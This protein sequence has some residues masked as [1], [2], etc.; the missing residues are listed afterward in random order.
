MLFILRFSK[1]IGDPQFIKLKSCSID[2]TGEGVALNDSL[3]ALSQ[4][5]GG[6]DRNLRV[7]LKCQTSVGNKITPN[8]LFSRREYPKKVT[9]IPREERLFSSLQHI[10]N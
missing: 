7:D 2:H 8:H 4:V 10:H 6:R 9:T 3:I 5:M 1:T